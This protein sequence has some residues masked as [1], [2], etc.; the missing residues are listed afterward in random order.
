M[1]YSLLT[2]TLLFIFFAHS[3]DSIQNR[4]C[5]IVEMFK[6]I[7]KTDKSNLNDSTIRYQS[8][9]DNFDQIFS[10][11]ES[12]GFIGVTNFKKKER[13]IITQGITRTLIHIFQIEPGLI[14]NDY[15]INLISSELRTGRFEKSYLI[16][17]LSIY[18]YDNKIKSPYSGILKEAL[19]K[20]EIND[21]EIQR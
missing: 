19:M 10:L 6:V 15:F 9:R 11:I 5:E 4:K 1:K 16:V 3:Q 20:W 8:F 18:V 21:Q 12:G 7:N 17:P 2:V 13:K 14:L